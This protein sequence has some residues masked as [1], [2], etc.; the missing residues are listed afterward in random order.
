MMAAVEV[1]CKC[2]WGIKV[3]P[4]NIIAVTCPKCKTKIQVREPIQIKPPEVPKEEPKVEIEKIE[5][6]AEEKKEEV[7]EK[8]KK[9]KK[10]I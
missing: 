9:R 3:N 7:A 8:P 10:V 4:V 2:G 6:P 5:I 1:K